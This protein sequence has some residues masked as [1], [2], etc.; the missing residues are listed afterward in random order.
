MSQYKTIAHWLYSTLFV[1]CSS[2][3]RFGSMMSATGQQCHSDHIVVMWL[4]IMC[5][6][7][8]CVCSVYFES[9]TWDELTVGFAEPPG[10]FDYSNRSVLSYHFYIPPQVLLSWYIYT[11]YTTHII[12]WYSFQLI[13]RFMKDKKIC[14]DWSVL[15]HE[16]CH[17]CMQCVSP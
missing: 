12:I 5:I 16:V 11:V 9:V 4:C 7:W 1:Y 8:Q 13:S 14:R 15:V 2:I 17:F 10:G 6:I 3:R